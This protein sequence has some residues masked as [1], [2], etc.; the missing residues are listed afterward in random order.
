MQNQ[1]II[2]FTIWNENYWHDLN[3]SRKYILSF[4]IADL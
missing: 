1:G 3:L 4:I 2:S